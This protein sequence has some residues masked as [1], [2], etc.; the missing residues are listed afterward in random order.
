MAAVVDTHAHFL[1]LELVE[2]CRAGGHPRFRV[3]DGRDGPWLVSASGTRFPVGPAFHDPEAILAGM[4]AAGVAV[5]VLSVAA[6]MFFYELEPDAALAASQV[7]NDGAAELARH[8]S[9]RLRAMASVPLNAPPAAAVEL[10]RAHGLGLRGVEIGASVGLVQLDA[11]ELDPFYAAA[12]ELGMTV[13]VHPYT[14]MVGVGIPPGLDRYFMSNTVGGPF[15]TCRAAVRMMLG[16]VFDRHPGLVVHLAHAGGSLPYQLARVDH[17][18][19]LREA[20]RETARRRPLDYLGN[21]LFDTVAYDARQLD[22]LASVAGVERIVFGTDLPFDM[23]DLT[24][25]AW[26]AGLDPGD[27][28]R[29]LEAN[30]ARAYGLEPVSA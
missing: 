19:G 1:P 20:V 28:E 9:G 11:A 2:L 10:R 17:T 22:F 24:G 26:A 8:S 5:S 25:I 14:S 13:F 18:Y 15:E 23:V 29:V 16:G 6:P 27:A 21:L 30:A 12:D 7:L 4:D 3:E